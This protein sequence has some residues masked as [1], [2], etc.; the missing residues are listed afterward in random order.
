MKARLS[1]QSFGETAFTPEGTRYAQ[2]PDDCWG[3]LGKRVQFAF[4]AL[5]EAWDGCTETDISR[6]H[7]RDLINKARTKKGLREIHDL[8]IITWYFGE[9]KKL[10]LIVRE[11]I[12]GT[13]EWITRLAKPFMSRLNDPAPDLPVPAP[14]KKMAG[15]AAKPP[16]ADAVPA[17]EAAR[18]RNA[19]EIVRTMAEL[20]L[21]PSLDAQGKVIWKGD[22]SKVDRYVMSYVRNRDADIRELLE[23]HR[24][25]LE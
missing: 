12:Q 16:P 17:D 6:T 14:E 19:E 18:E 25:A 9:L 7:L 23:A 1:Y 13:N 15:P 8:R 21:T 22:W 4:R 20:G 10:G 3:D 5:L 2:F 24:P 11:R